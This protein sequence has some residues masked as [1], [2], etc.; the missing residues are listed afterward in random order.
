MEW[1]PYVPVAVRHARARR[2]MNR[3][4]K[5][6]KSIQ[7]VEIEGRTIARSFWGKR[8]CD[9]LESFSDYA[10]RLPR[11]RTYVRNGSVCHLEIHPG[12][13]GAIVMGSELYDVTIRIGKLK[14]AVWKS[15]KHRCSGQIGSMLE[16]LQG[17]L[18][19]QVMGVVTDRQH[20]LFPKPGEIRFDCSCP[21]WA[22]MCKHVASVLYGVGSRLDDRPESLFLLR[23][24]DT[25]ELIATGMALPGDAATDDALADDA[26]AGIFGIDLDTGDAPPPAP[27]APAKPRRPARRRVAAPGRQASPAAKAR[28]VA[29]SAASAG[30]AR[31]VAS[32][33]TREAKTSPAAPPR[34]RAAA[35][36]QAG[37]ASKASAGRA[38]KA[39]SSVTRGAKTSPAATPRKRAAAKTQ[40]VPA[41]KAS[42]GNA[43]K[44]ASSVTREAKT[45]PAAAVRKRAAAK[46]QDLPASKASAERARKAASSIARGTNTPPTAAPG[47]RAAARKAADAS[48]PDIRPTGK[49]VARLRRRCGLTVAQFAARLGVSAVTVYRWEATPG[50]LNLHARP[51]NALTSLYRR[52]GKPAR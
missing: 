38:R 21:D 5:K 37:P 32:R 9:H 29:A 6:G 8:W 33:V 51:L 52:S 50:R 22:A 36:A 24:V 46:A 49:W 35:K 13:I 44:A 27:K 7:P 28:D 1:R 40:D 18:S 25:A 15:I 43:R 3:L 17:K 47:K 39:A 34:K 20:G 30:N 11:G 31:K 45:S 19:K 23:G 14:A 16:L 41:S 4:R 10:N 42:A 12:R 48:P 2:E 26:L